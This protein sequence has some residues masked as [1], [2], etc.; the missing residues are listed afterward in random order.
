MAAPTSAL[1][2]LLAVPLLVTPAAAAPTATVVISHG[3]TV[4]FINSIP[5][6]TDLLGVTLATDVSL[7]V[8]SGKHMLAPGARWA[9]VF[10]SSCLTCT[11]TYAYRVTAG[12][13]PPLAGLP[14]LPAALPWS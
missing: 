1:V 7:A 8:P 4:T 3:G 2:G 13:L 6:R 5:A 9:E 11:V 14:S 10:N 12:I